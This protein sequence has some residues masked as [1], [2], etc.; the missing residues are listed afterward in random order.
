MHELVGSWSFGEEN[1]DGTLC[2]FSSSVG[3]ALAGSVQ[4]ILGK[5]V[6]FASLNQIPFM[7]VAWKIKFTAEVLFF[8]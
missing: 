8:Q 3:G 7:Y 4:S 6:C 1:W 2:C 5:K